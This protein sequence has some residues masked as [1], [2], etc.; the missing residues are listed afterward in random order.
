MVKTAYQE[1]ITFNEPLIYY[2]LIDLNF[3]VYIFPWARRRS[4]INMEETLQDIEDIDFLILNQNE[5]FK[6][7]KN[8][9]EELVIS[10]EEIAA[11]DA[12]AMKQSNVEDLP[13]LIFI[14]EKSGNMRVI[15]HEGG[16]TETT[17]SDTKSGDLAINR[18]SFCGKCYKR[19]LFYEKHGENCEIN[20]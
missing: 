8:P 6:E 5:L 16:S 14:E 20:S 11:L 9:S 17:K 18:C 2:Y 12:S 1:F 19:E 10:E 4:K 15:V 3:F 7:E 13:K